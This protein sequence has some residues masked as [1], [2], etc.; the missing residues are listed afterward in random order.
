MGRLTQQGENSQ[1]EDKA[2]E[3]AI[4]DAAVGGS[5]TECYIVGPQVEVVAGHNTIRLTAL[6]PPN[7]N[8]WHIRYELLTDVPTPDVPAPKNENPMSRAWVTIDLP[9]VH[10]KT[11]AEDA[12]RQAMGFTSTLRGRL[13]EIRE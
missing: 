12:L 9:T 4:G 6:T 11:N 13:D 10:G 8:Q 5:I 2:F 7:S 3:V 1:M